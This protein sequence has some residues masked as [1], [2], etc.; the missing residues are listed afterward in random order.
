MKILDLLITLYVKLKNMWSSLSDE[1]KKKIVLAI[2][3]A[4]EKILRV[5]FKEHEKSKNNRK[6]SNQEKANA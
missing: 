1:E 3:K 4:F 6:E 2:A 5:Y